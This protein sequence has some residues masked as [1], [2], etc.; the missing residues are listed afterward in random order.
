MD[1]ERN[2][3]AQSFFTAG[4]CNFRVF[5]QFVGNKWTF[6]VMTLNKRTCWFIHVS[7]DYL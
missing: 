7:A 4:H 3:L 5:V 1:R 2:W 6:S